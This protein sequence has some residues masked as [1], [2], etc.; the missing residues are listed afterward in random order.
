MVQLHSFITSALDGGEWST[1]SPGRFTPGE[2]N[3][4]T[5]NRS[6]S[7]PRAGLDVLEKR[8]I[9]CTLPGFEPRNIQSFAVVVMKVGCVYCEV[10]NEMLSFRSIL[11]VF[12][13]SKCS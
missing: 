12:Y 13:A 4:C 5:L 7:G 11:N 3:L 9:S 8:K 2:R 1:S 6:L 10:G